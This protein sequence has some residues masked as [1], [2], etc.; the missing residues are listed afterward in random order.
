MSSASLTRRSG[1]VGTSSDQEVDLDVGY[2]INAESSKQKRSVGIAHKGKTYAPLLKSWISQFRI[3]RSEFSFVGF[4][5]FNRKK[6][7]DGILPI[8]KR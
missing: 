5:L 6:D 7:I 2:K 1:T 4:N 3:Q 8:D